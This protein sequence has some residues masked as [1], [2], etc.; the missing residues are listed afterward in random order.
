MTFANTWLNDDG[1]KVPFGTT[2]GVQSE[3]GTV[4]TKGMKKELRLDLDFSNLPRSGTAVEGDNM[5]LPAGAAILS[6]ELVTTDSFSGAITIGTMDV[7]GA[8]ISAAGIIASATPLIDTVLTGGALMNT[9]TLVDA[10][11]AVAGAATSGEAELVV[12]YSI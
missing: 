10:Y 4:H 6:A 12:T 11:I 3:G 5:G 1:L 7:D 2:D 9:V 8:V